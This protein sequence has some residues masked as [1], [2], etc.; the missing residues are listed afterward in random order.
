[1]A[2]TYTGMSHDC[3]ALLMEQVIADLQFKQSLGFLAQLD[4]PLANVLRQ[5]KAAMKCFSQV[6]FLMF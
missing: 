2:G 5:S 1:M 3:M 4:L 6:S